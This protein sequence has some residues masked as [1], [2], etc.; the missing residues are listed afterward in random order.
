MATPK[1]SGHTRRLPTRPPGQEFPPCPMFAPRRVRAFPSMARVRRRARATAR[2]A[3]K[4]LKPAWARSA[5]AD[6]PPAP[7]A[8][9]SA[10]PCPNEPESS[11]ESERTEA[12][13]E[14]ERIQLPRNPVRSRVAQARQRAQSRTN[15]S[16]S[17]GLQ[18]ALSG[19]QTN[20][21]RARIRTNLKLRRTPIEPKLVHDEVLGQGRKALGGVVRAA[22]CRRSMPQS[23]TTKLDRFDCQGRNVPRY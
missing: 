9:S 11:R 17:K 18:S 16:C 2:S 7:L 22:R 20:P 4:A 1:R 19:I 21:S 3:W 23:A 15:P 13:L 8:G 12:E 6:P 10:Q 14:F 5:E